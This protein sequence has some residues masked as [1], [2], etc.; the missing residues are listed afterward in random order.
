MNRRGD[1]MTRNWLWPAM[2]AGV[3]V[4]GCQPKVVSPLVPLPLPIESAPSTKLTVVGTGETA[5][6][7]REAALEQ[8]V[9]QVILPPTEPENAPS[10]EFV[11]SMIRGH[12]VASV[13]QDFRKRYYVTVELTISQLGINYQEMYH[14]AQL[15]K[16]ECRALRKDA[17]NEE[18]LRRL[19]EQRAEKAEEALAEARRRY[20]DRLLELKA[21]I[22]KFEARTETPAEAD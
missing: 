2:L 4:A 3:L 6:K 8:M 22:E 15:H 11:A 13:A 21:R 12:N 1:A 20:E 14:A 5:E 10:P 7:A 19:V 17:E 16:Q 18:K 9:R